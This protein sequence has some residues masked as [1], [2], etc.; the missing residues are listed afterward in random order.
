PVLSMTP[1]FTSAST[2]QA[3][4]AAHTPQLQFHIKYGLPQVE[5]KRVVCSIPD[6]LFSLEVFLCPLCTPQGSHAF[7]KKS[8]PGEGEKDFSLEFS[9]RESRSGIW[10]TECLSPSVEANDDLHLHGYADGTQRSSMHTVKC[11]SCL[12]NE[13]GS[14]SL[15]QGFS[16]HHADIYP[17]RL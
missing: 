8:L 13:R 4:V 5:P 1:D 17:M 10:L 16:P 9:G 6:F 15:S 3:L 12:Q 2:N 11:Q 7:S 14:C